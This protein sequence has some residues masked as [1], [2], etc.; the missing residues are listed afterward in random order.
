VEAAVLATLRDVRTP[1]VGGAATSAEFTAGVRR[2]LGW[3]RWALPPEEEGPA[4]Y[5]WGV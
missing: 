4:S 5:G 1:D 2:H 3:V